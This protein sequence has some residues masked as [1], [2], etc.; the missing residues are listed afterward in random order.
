M[1]NKYPLVVMAVSFV[2]FGIIISNIILGKEK[3]LGFYANLLMAVSFFVLSISLIFYQ[4]KNKDID[5]KN[6]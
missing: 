2:L 1:K 6:K 5:K 4:K 3:D